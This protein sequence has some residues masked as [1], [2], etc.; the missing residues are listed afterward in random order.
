MAAEGEQDPEKEK[1]KLKEDLT[2]AKHNAQHFK[3]LS[4]RAL[5]RQVPV[6]IPSFLC[7]LLPA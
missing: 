2:K 5:S 6:P 7:A 1:E 3:V 4:L